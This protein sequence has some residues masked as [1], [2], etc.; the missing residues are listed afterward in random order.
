[1]PVRPLPPFY[2]LNLERKY[3]SL[4]QEIAKLSSDEI[5]ALGDTP[6]KSLTLLLLLDQISRN[7][8]RGTPFPFIN[9]DPLSLKL[10]E[11][12]IFKSGHDKQQPPWKRIWYYV[13]LEHSE[14][15]HYQE[16]ALAKF[17][18]VCWECRE[19]QYKENHGFMKIGLAYAWKHFEVIDKFGRFPHRNKALGRENTEEEEK[20]L[21]EG[22]G[23]EL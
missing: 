9:C 15:I 1:M 12:S 17:G 2:K 4:I 11:H 19:G 14:N 18:E 20:Y 5:I 13:P 21:A 22:G 10:A 6:Q 16:L 8:F 3:E 7:S 23:R